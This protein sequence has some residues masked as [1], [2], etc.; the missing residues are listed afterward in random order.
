MK[1]KLLS[2]AVATAVIFSTLLPFA[3]SNRVSA[4]EFPIMN[5]PKS[6]GVYNFMYT[7]YEL[8]DE[9]LSGTVRLVFESVNSDFTKTLTMSDDQ[10]VY[11]SLDPADIAGSSEYIVSVTGG[12]TLPLDTYDITLSYQDASAGP[13][14]Y[15][16]ATSVIITEAENVP[17]RVN[18]H[19]F[20]SDSYQGH[21]YTTNTA[22]KDHL[23][24][25]ASAVWHYEGDGF[26]VFAA[27]DCLGKASVYRFWSPTYKHHFFTVKS[28]EKDQIIATNSA[29]W[30]YEG[31]AFCAETSEDHGGLPIY[32]LWNATRKAHH[33]TISNTEKTNLEAPGTG[34]TYEGIAFY[35]FLLSVCAG[36]YTTGC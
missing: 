3:K 24:E 20:W 8:P 34:W 4:T 1:R 26:R 16:K 27:N 36:G 14:A 9:P 29:N 5:Y 28:A 10:T 17:T 35:G 31:V 23:V 22:E 6:G 15:V 18:V 33:Y 7:Q 32:R 13:L 19:R 30:N 2:A 11:L 21:F 12:N 25:T